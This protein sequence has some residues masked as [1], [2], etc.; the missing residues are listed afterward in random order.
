[1]HQRSV[2]APGNCS[3]LFSFQTCSL[4]NFF[5]SYPDV[6]GILEPQAK[7]FL[8]G[9]F[10]KLFYT[11]GLRWTSND[12]LAAF[13]KPRVGPK[14]FDFLGSPGNPYGFSCLGVGYHPT[15]VCL[16]GFLALHRGAGVLTYGVK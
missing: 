13:W 3:F 15:V 8:L 5:F 7:V 11:L 2:V 14:R 4:S 6:S 10:C 12:L 16:K 9:M 1:M